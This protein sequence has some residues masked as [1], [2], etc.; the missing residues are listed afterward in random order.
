VS[1]TVVSESEDGKPMADATNGK[2]TDFNAE[3]GKVRFT[4]NAN[5]LPWVLPPDVAEG[6]DLTHS[7]H[8]FSE[9]KLSVHTLKAGKYDVKID[10]QSVGKFTG[11]Q[12]ESG[13]ELEANEKTPQY[14]QA[15]QVA[16]LNKKRNDEAYRPIRD[17][18][19]ALKGKRRDLQKATDANDPQLDA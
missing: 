16:M 2:V 18:Y 11:D 7:G 19:G 12:L 3:G 6:V 9:E 1:R 8:R 13:I 4:L 5:A 15:L 17:Q 14:Q 10:G